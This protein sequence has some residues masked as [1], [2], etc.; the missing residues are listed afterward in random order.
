MCPASAWWPWAGVVSG[1]VSSSAGRAGAGVPTAGVLI[2]ARAGV[3]VVCESIVAREAR[4]PAGEG[5]EGVWGNRGNPGSGGFPGFPWRLAVS[6]SGRF[7]RGIRGRAVHFPRSFA[8]WGP[9]L[10][11]GGGRRGLG[12]LEPGPC[13]SGAG[14]GS[15]FPSAFPDWSLLLSV[16]SCSRA[17]VFLTSPSCL[18]EGVRSGTRRRRAAG[19]SAQAAGGPGRERGAQLP[20]AR[21]LRCTASVPGVCA[22]A[23]CQLS[24]TQALPVIVWGAAGVTKP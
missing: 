10:F 2:S 13:F 22:D 9:S 6:L 8:R 1:G 14:G 16:H 17:V 5:R 15:G 7:R 19:A 3:G 18:V 12:N 11:S 20:H 4:P 23:G 24:F 21:A